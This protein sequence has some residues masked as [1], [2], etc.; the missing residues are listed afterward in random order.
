M[1][2]LGS[3]HKASI[4]TGSEGKQ[5]DERV[6]TRDVDQDVRRIQVRVLRVS[7]RDVG[8]AHHQRYVLIDSNPEAIRVTDPAEVGGANL[9]LSRQPYDLLGRRRRPAPRGEPVAA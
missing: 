2:L 4:N 8:V 1:G 7:S 3:G 9:R 5:L 6:D